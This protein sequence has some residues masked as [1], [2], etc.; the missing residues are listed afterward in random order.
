MELVIDDVRVDGALDGVV[1]R[2]GLLRVDALLRSRTLRK[3]GKLR[4]SRLV[5]LCALD[6]TDRLLL[7]VD[8]GE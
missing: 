2:D 4:S 5:T 6:S 1:L 3:E 7:E 8:P